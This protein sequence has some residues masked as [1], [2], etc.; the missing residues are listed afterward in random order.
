MIGVLNGL[1]WGIFA[2]AVFALALRGTQRKQIRPVPAPSEL[3]ASP[4]RPKLV[5]ERVDTIPPAMTVR[6]NRFR[7]EQ[8][9][10]KIEGIGPFRG[11]LLNKMGIVT[12]DDLLAVGATREGR[13]RIANR[14]NVGYG[15]VLSWV[16]RA[17]LL[18]VRGVGKQYSELLESAG[19]SSVSDLSTRNAR[20]LWR[21]LRLVNRERM[22]VRRVPPPKTIESWVY[23]AKRLTRFG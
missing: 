14:I 2:A 18:R 5:I 7:K 16:C 11:R 8:D 6:Q 19:V 9:V 12:V 17:D 23:N 3:R 10:K 20:V 22:L 1:L 15:T 21:R 4:P 13:Q